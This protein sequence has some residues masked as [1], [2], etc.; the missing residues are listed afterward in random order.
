MAEGQSEQPIGLI[1]LGNTGAGKSFLANL[2]LPEEKFAH[3]LSLTAVTKKTVYEKLKYG[4]SIVYVFDIPGLIEAD[5]ED[6][7]A[8]ESNKRE[9]DKAFEICPNSIVI[10]VFGIDNISG[11]IR[12]ED[13]LAFKE[14]NKAYPFKTESLT[15]VMNR[16]PIPIKRP[17]NYEGKAITLLKKNF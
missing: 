15:I 8:I 9:I 2:I 16:V 3:E 13:I 12:G 1:F 11:R 14:L 4:N 10:Y 17:D 7:E 5:E 6:G